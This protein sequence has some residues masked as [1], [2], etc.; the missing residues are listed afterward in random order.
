MRVIILG[1]PGSGKGTQANLLCEKLGLAHISTGDILREAVRLGTPRGLK[2]RPFMDQG[3]Y[4]PDQLVNDI[5]ADRFARA[6]RPRRFL[7]D[8]YPR[9]LTQ[10]VSFDRVLKQQSFPLDAVVVL[11]VPEE[12]LVRRM[13]GRRVCPRDGSTYHLLFDPPKKSPE[14]CDQCGT[15]LE[16]RVDDAE[17]TV[18]ERL[19][20]FQATLTPVIDYYRPTGI[21]REVSGAGPIAEIARAMLT[22][23]GAT[24]GP[25]AGRPRTGVRKAAAPKRAGA[26]TPRTKK[27]GAVGAK[28][29]HARKRG[30]TDRK[31][32]G[33]RTAKKSMRSSRT[34]GAP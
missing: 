20:T 32:A 29:A 8:G 7:M 17:R 25:P 31:T 11:R 1:P 3:K 22:S 12:E 14:H 6:D 23:L 15:R 18:R 13:S 27:P 4:V 28:A 21:L 9:T 33:P 24:A 10:A 16:Q 30:A 2:A 19:R 26:K 5:I 34:A